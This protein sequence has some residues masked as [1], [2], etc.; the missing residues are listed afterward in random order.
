MKIK[1]FLESVKRV[2]EAYFD[3]GVSPEKFCY[4]NSNRDRSFKKYPSVINVS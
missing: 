1:G 3:L 4:S 2:P